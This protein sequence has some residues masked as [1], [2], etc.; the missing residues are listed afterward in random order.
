MEDE[1]SL[2]PSALVSQLPDPVQDQVHDLLADGVVTPGVVIG[3][4]LLTGEKLLRMEQLPVDTSPHLV[5]D[6]GLKVHE[7]R[8][9]YVLAGAGL[10]EE[11]VKGVIAPSNSLVGWHLAIGLDAVLKA[12]E[13]P[14]SVSNLDSGLA[15][16]D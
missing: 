6:G 7:D 11:G 16:V 12:V 15:D 10:R 14:A 5:N 9:G 3:S 13:L 1:E 8:P 4:I 2:E